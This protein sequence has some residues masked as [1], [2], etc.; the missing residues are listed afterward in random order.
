MP[1]PA[2]LAKKTRQL[3][4]RKTAASR[5]PSPK[6]KS[7]N[8]PKTNPTNQTKHEM[9]RFDLANSVQ[10]CRKMPSHAVS[11]DKCGTVGGQNSIRSGCVSFADFCRHLPSLRHQLLLHWHAAGGGRVLW[12]QGAVDGEFGAGWGGFGSEFVENVKAHSVRDLKRPTSIRLQS[13]YFFQLKR[14][15]IW[16]TPVRLKFS[17][18]L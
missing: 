15:P 12:C 18:V 3:F 1:F 9:R 14:C 2:S 16:Q 13:H 7:T 11:R 10:P 4:L 6:K 8:N 17:T 5:Y